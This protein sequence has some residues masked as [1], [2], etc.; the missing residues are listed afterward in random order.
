MVHYF[1]CFREWDILLVFYLLYF[2]FSFVCVT[3][4]WESMVVLFTVWT[5]S[6]IW[7]NLTLCGL[8][9]FCYTFH[10]SDSSVILPLVTKLL[11]FKAPQRRWHILFHPHKEIS[12][13]YFLQ[14]LLFFFCSWWPFIFIKLLLSPLL[15]P[16]T[17]P[18]IKWLLSRCLM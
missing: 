14:Y 9:L 15:K 5:F 4:S 8:G 18:Y 1:S 7:A 17:A 2:L 16:R 12:D 13:F 6:F 10:M 3:R 11:A